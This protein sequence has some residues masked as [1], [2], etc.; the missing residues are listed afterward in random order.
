MKRI[1]VLALAFTQMQQVSMQIELELARAELKEMKIEVASDFDDLDTMVVLGT[2]QERS[3][4]AKL[5]T[6]TNAMPSGRR[7][8]PGWTVR[9][10]PALGYI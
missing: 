4:L 9:V 10:A 7:Y 5:S 2:R 8:D 6:K 1:I 3:E